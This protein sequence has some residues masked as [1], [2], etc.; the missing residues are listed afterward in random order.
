MLELPTVVPYFDLS[1]QH[2]DAALLRAMRRWGSAERF[3]ALIEGIRADQPDAAFRSS[4]IV[5]FPGETEADHETLL[6]FLDAADLDWAGFF[7]FSPEDGTPGGDAS[8]CRARVAR[9][10]VARRV[11]RGA[12]THHPRLA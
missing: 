6:E 7:A 5:G 2:A 9:G 12:G 11:R 1:L 10:G 3:L 8:R 4:F